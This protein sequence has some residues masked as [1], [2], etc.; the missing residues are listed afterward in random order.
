[1]A[2]IFSIVHQDTKYLYGINKNED[3]VKDYVIILKIKK[4][5]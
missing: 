2:R 5:T 1:M 3:M 4:L